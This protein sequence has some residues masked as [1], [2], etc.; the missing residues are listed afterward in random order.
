M[1][2]CANQ[3]LPALCLHLTCDTC[4]GSCRFNQPFFHFILTML[5]PAQTPLLAPTVYR[6]K[7]DLFY[8]VMHNT[9]PHKPHL[10]LGSNVYPKGWPRHSGRW[11]MHE[12]LL[13]TPSMSLIPSSSDCSIPSLAVISPC[14]GSTGFPQSLPADGTCMSGL[15]CYWE[16]G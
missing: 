13:P 6:I 9:P 7:P 2:P 11:A 10:P 14:G 16:P 3:G 12:K 5:C 1:N 8:P 15:R 4:G